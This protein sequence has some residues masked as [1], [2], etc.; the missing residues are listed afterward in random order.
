[1]ARFMEGRSDSSHSKKD[2]RERVEKFRGG[3]LDANVI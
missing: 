3:D 2:E 1:M